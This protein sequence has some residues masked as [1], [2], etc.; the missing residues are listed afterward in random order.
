[1][2]S[3]NKLRGLPIFTDEDELAALIG[4]DYITLRKYAY[5]NKYYY[6]RYFITKSSGKQREIHQPNKQMKGI[7]AWI[8]R[9]I[10]DKLIPSP[11][12]TAYRKGQS[13]IAHVKPHLDNH[14]F[15][16]IDIKDF[17]PSISLYRIFNLFKSLD[18]NERACS[19]LTGLTTTNY[20]IPQGGVT[21]PTLSNLVCSKLDNRIIGYTQ[22]HRIVYTRYADDITL[23]SDDEK[24]LRQTKSMI[25]KI[26]NSFNLFL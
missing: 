21:S 3:P 1:M 26:F 6:K 2:N 5:H 25:Y 11:V 22:K 23:S 4:I 15:L 7:Q 24:T 19:L 8:L 18:Y 16:L 14:F 9:N 10:L 20:H 12:A 13:I 17:F